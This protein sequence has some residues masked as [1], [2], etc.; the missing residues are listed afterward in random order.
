MLLYVTGG[1]AVVVGALSV[2]A[3]LLMLVPRFAWR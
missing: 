3:W 2:T 1:V